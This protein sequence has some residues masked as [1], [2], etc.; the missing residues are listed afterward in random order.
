MI[1]NYIAAVQPLGPPLNRP[2]NLGTPGSQAPTLFNSILSSIIGFITV[3]AFIYFMFTLITGALGIISAGGDKGKIETARS[4]LTTGI[5]GV[6]VVVAA[7]F[8]VDLIAT[9][10][11]LP[12]FLDPGGTISN[13]SP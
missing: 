9:L 10:L 6:I 8:I 1:K 11:G 5:I 12:D 7:F 13:L 2:G 3:I 4:R